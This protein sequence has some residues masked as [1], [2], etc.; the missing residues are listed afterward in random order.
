MI[1]KTQAKIGLRVKWQSLDISIPPAYGK[2]EE[3]GPS[4]FLDPNEI[5]IRYDDEQD[6]TTYLDSG[7]SRVFPA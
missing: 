1:T 4:E 7:A 5:L 6:G 2:I 3:I